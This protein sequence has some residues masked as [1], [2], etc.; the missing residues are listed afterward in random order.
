M[1]IHRP[2]TIHRQEG[3]NSRESSISIGAEPDTDDS[4]QH[5][6]LDAEE[7]IWEER[8]YYAGDA[9]WEVEA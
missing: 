1:Q 7:E 9:A 6:T 5:T 2:T 4:N 3:F 8:I